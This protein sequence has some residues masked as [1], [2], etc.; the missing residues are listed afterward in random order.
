M[1]GADTAATAMM[2]RPLGREQAALE[3]YAAPRAYAAPSPPLIRQE[4]PAGTEAAKWAV[5]AAAFIGL[6]ATFTMHTI[7]LR[8]QNVG[9]GGAAISLSVA[10]QALAIC[11]AALLGKPIIA[12]IGLRRT[13]PVSSVCCAAALVGIFFSRDLYAIG[14]LRIV[15]AIGLTFPVIASE[16]LVT[17]RGSSDNRGSVIAWYTT[18]L[19]AGA[20]AG[21]MLVSF[22][23]ITESGAFL[24]GASMLLF[25]SAALGYCLSDAEGKTTRH[26]TS[27][28][29]LAF[30]PAVF[31]AAFIFGVA[32]NGGLSML[33][34]Y[35]ALN[36]YASAQ[37]ANLAVFAALGA[38]LLQFPIGRL[39]AKR[40]ANELLTILGIFALCLSAFLPMAIEKP[41]LAA[42]VSTGLGGSIEGIYTVAL[43]G[44]SRERRVQSL[45]MLN[46]CFISV[47]SLGEVVGPAASSVSMEMLGSHG[48]VVTLIVAFAIYVLGMM[49]RTMFKAEYV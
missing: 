16:Y 44:I 48:F 43:I 2:L 15:F 42:L 33:P 29:T 28:R 3:T 9:I 19:G 36:G 30:M 4:R 18:A 20:I 41:A 24:A 45:P 10:L 39:A 46:A 11:V 27:W 7:N 5:G 38:V 23:G 17:V 32:D 6:I 40:N 37:A 26:S 34:V 35:A 21:P 47:C 14:L 31:C 8:M 49:N 25:G 12:T 13:L 22:M 1:S